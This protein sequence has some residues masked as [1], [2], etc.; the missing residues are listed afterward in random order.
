MTAPDEKKTF[1]G[2]EIHI[3]A[4]EVI[5]RIEE[6]N[7]SEHRDRP[8]PVYTLGAFNT[9]PC[10]VCGKR[11]C[12]HLKPWTEK[13]RF[14]PGVRMD[15]P[16]G[17]KRALDASFN[18]I[19]PADMEYALRSIEDKRKM[20]VCAECGERAIPEFMVS[21]LDKEDRPAWLCKECHQRLGGKS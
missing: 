10:A 6:F 15:V 4:D 14:V 11:E 9:A 17:L 5:G 20:V 19:P 1:N 13:P 12:E 18:E 16:L 3:D 8:M 7:P 2:I 21:V